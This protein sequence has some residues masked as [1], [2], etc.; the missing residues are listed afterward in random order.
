[1]SSILNDTK[2]NLGIS[3]DYT[4]FD[5]DVKMHINSALSTLG[6]LGIGPA[7]GFEVTDDTA[8]WADFLGTD[9]RLNSAKTYVYLKTRLVFD[10]PATSYLIAAVQ[11]QIEELEF[12]LNVV[13]EETGWTNP[14][15]APIEETVYDGGE[16]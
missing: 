4:A 15:P 3:A 2:K 16:A 14:L 12:R 1:M 11:K 7:Q 9:L 13:R 6:Q 10:P 8:Q 5:L